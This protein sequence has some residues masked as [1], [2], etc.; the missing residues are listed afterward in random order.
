MA[1]ATAAAATAAVMAESAGQAAP[2]EADA[3][4]CPISWGYVSEA[5]AC[6]RCRHT[7]C[8]VCINA[9]IDAR[10]MDAACLHVQAS[11]LSRAGGP[12]CSGTPATAQTK[13]GGGSK[14]QTLRAIG[15]AIT[16]SNQPSTMI[17]P[18]LLMTNQIQCF[19]LYVTFGLAPR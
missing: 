14:S 11:R 5:I 13:T 15:P 9:H 2:V 18:G 7:F 17:T 4:R 8:R 6:G 3:D 12:C 19:I 16:M 1:A 10:G